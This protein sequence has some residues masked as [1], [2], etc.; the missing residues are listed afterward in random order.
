MPLASLFVLAALLLLAA[1]L[2]GQLALG[3]RAMRAALLGEDRRPRR[4]PA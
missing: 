2:A 1:T 4:L 3:W